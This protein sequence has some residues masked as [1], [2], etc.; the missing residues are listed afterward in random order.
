MLLQ[1]SGAESSGGGNLAG[2]LILGFIILV[3][4]C[5]MAYASIYR[6]KHISTY[7]YCHHVGAALYLVLGLFVSIA[8]I[9]KHKEVPTIIVGV[10]FVA[11]FLTVAYVHFRQIGR[12]NETDKGTPLA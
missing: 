9:I 5:P 10:P 12:P 6:A 4:L 7:K 11:Y 1:N 8:L 2:T 3:V